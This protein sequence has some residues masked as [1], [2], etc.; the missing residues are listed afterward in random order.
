MV[1]IE[2]NTW[3][4]TITR[5]RIVWLSISIFGDMMATCTSWENG[6]QFAS[7]CSGRRSDRRLARECM[8]IYLN[9]FCD[10]IAEFVACSRWMLVLLAAELWPV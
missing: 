10:F 5:N 2:A 9:D 7:V 3:V 1:E 6:E 4:S 8:R